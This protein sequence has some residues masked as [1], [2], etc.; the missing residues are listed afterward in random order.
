MYYTIE[1]FNNLRQLGEAGRG[2][3][4][5]ESREQTRKSDTSCGIVQTQTPVTALREEGPKEQ[6][7]RTKSSA[8]GSISAACEKDILNKKC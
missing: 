2:E 7:D 1:R 5:E 4:G 6:T 3:T 8:Q